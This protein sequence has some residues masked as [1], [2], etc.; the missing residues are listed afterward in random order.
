M[1]LINAMPI[2][3]DRRARSH[4]EI[5]MPASLG[6]AIPPKEICRVIGEERKAGGS[7]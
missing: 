6:D 1:P 2:A 7:D 3:T 4:E 5:R